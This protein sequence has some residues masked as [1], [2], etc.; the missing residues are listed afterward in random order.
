[1]DS[2]NLKST[3]PIS[4]LYKDLNTNQKKAVQTFEGPV[5]V[6]AGA[7]SGKTRVLVY[8]IAGL[9]LEKKCPWEQILAVTFTNKAAKE[10]K[11]RV[12]ELLAQYGVDL[13]YTPWIGTFHSV[14]AQILRENI[15]L[16][17]DRRTFTI[18]DQADQLRLIKK[19]FQDL[20]IDQ[21]MKEPKSIRSQI[22]LCKRMGLGPNELH[23]V[24][25]LSYDP[26][27]ENIYRSYEK[28]LKKASAFD[29]ESLLF[30]TYRLMLKNPQFLKSLQER[31][32]YICI[33]EYQ[34]TN[35]IQ[36]L[37]IKK[38]AERHKNICVV[39]DEDQSIYGWRGADISNIM[40]FEKDFENCAIFFLEENYR[41]TKNIIQGANH[42]IAHNQNR[43]GKI[44]KANKLEGRKIHIR[45]AFN[46]YEEGRF[47]AHNIQFLCA[48]EG[49]H[50]GDFAILYRTNAQSRS[51]EDH[52]RMLRI[53][54][55]IVGGVRFYE[56]KEIK[57]ALSYLKLILNS[58][59]DVSF[60]AIINS[61]RR[62]M[63]KNSLYRLQEESFQSQIS[64]YEC[65]K[66]QVKGH[67]LIKGKSLLEVKKFI[68]CIEYVK[69]QQGQIPL[70]DLYT[71]LLNRSGYMEYIDREKSMESKSRLENLQEFG[72]VIAQKE[73][74]NGG[75]ILDLESFLEEM[76]LLTQED[77]TEDLKDCVTLM[78]LHNSK[79]LEFHT[80]FI[81][82]MEEGLFPSFQ[83]LEDNN[84]EEERRLA[85][86]GMTRAQERLTLSYVKRRK[87]WGRDQYNPP[88]CFL[89][90]IPRHLVQHEP[91]PLYKT[92]RD[93]R[94]D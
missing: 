49:S 28:A 69:R 18:Y 83:S 16:F 3:L 73:K 55:K 53:P 85:Y 89:S 75:S 64:L 84:L 4:S 2:T 80:V 88:S 52:L 61:P 14:C 23:R 44:L 48:N 50:F 56:R 68:D 58:S 25:H 33:D 59:D 6:L 17:R 5:L 19:V 13:P 74:Q 40:N 30:E 79:G 86:V 63:G 9:F 11:D 57:E 65:L 45:E 7:G 41:S 12:S 29:F 93:F 21:R 70:Y 51:L 32:R 37:L 81:S 78:T 66:G 34:D 46:E 77:K 35:M 60:L 1:M 92:S 90:E 42:L 54:Y 31:F 47:I 22:N 62:G 94:L 10:M 38:I 27:F 15:H 76:S 36:Y 72:N 8:R 82:G 43:K 20:N 71:L 91:L 67:R 24:P 87:F 26:Q 39:G